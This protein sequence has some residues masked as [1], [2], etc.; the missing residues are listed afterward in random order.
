VSSEVQNLPEK[1]ILIH[2]L[3]NIGS[4]NLTY[5]QK[6]AKRHP[7]ATMTTFLPSPGD[8]DISD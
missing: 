5:R 4:T 6:I 3:L 7:G 2:C 8:D 1:K